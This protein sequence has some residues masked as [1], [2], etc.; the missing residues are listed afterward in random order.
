MIVHFPVA[1]ILVGF[2]ADVLFLFFKKEVCLSKAGL[3]LMV[4][5]TLGAA[6]AFLSGNLFTSEPTEGSIV[7]IFE[8]HETMALA[9]LLIMTVGSILRLALIYFKIDKPV[10]RWVVF[11]LYALGA[12]CVGLTGNLGG[13]MVMDYMMGL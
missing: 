3:W 7:E 5:G 12:V 13:T 2:L 1:L 11:A 10:Y 9:T 4:L 6:A 8:R